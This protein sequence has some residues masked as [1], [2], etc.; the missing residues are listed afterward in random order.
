MLVGNFEVIILEVQSIYKNLITCIHFSNSIS[1]KSFNKASG[2]KIMHVAIVYILIFLGS[3][4]IGSIPFSWIVVK[5]KLG[6]DLRTIGSGNVGGRNVYRATKSRGWAA[7]AGFLDISRSIAAIAIPYMVSKNFYFTNNDVLIELFIWPEFGIF[8]CFALTITGL[9]AIL[10]H[11]WPI[12][13][14]SHGG[15]GIT[16]VFA[17]TLFANPILL[18]FWAILWPIC[19]SFIGYSAINYIFVTF[20]IAIIAL[21]LPQSMLMPWANY[22]LGLAILLFLVALIMLTRQRDN[23]RKI[24]T[25]EAKK[26]RVFKAL[27]GKSKLGD[28]MLK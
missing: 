5:L 25:G 11:N 22:N 23:I 28:E 2:V 19:I 17:T 7:L 26:M 4:L 18:A 1:H 15:R 24:R 6:E 21:F 3:Y 20:L 12:Y 8:T 27:K 16:V 9:G 13:L 14:L 10:G